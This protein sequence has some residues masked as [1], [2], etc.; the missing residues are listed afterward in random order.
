MRYGECI[1]KNGIYEPMAWRYIDTTGIQV[2]AI[3]DEKE[4]DIYLRGGI[5]SIQDIPD[6]VVLLQYL[7]QSISLEYV[8]AGSISNRWKA[9][10]RRK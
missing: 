10:W 9:G 8:D 2:Y 7:G 4:L 6:G 5:V 3:R 1:C